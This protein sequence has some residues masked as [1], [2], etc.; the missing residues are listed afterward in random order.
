MDIELATI[1]DILDEL[2][3][4]G[5]RFVFIGESPTNTPK[6]GRTVVAAQ[7]IDQKDL[8]RLIRIGVEELR[9]QS[10]DPIEPDYEG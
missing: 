10:N 7:A 2:R 8:C 4:R 6:P 1:D 9:N 5:M 3:Y